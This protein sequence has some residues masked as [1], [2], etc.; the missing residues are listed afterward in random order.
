MKI[1]TFKHRVCGVTFQRQYQPLLDYASEYG[2]EIS[3]YD[4]DNLEKL[5][6]DYD[7]FF[8]CSAIGRNYY[9]AVKTL[10]EYGHPAKIILDYDDGIERLVPPHNSY[11]ATV[12]EQDIDYKMIDGREI[13]WKSGKTSVDVFGKPVQ[14]NAEENKARNRYTKE[15]RGLADKI[16]TTNT[17]L[18]GYLSEE[19]TNISVIPNYINPAYYERF[20]RDND[21]QFRIGWVIS[22]SHIND[23]VNM[24]P[25]LYEM[26]EKIPNAKLVIFTY[27]QIQEFEFFHPRCE[28][29][30]GVAF[31]RGYH[32]MFS[33]LQLDLGICHVENNE[34]N[35][36]KSP[37]KWLEYSACNVPTIASNDLY[38]QYGKHKH[39]MWVYNTK[40]EFVKEVMYLSKRP[41]LRKK[42]ADNARKHIIDNFTPDKV[43][44][45][46]HEVFSE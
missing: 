24:K 21:G 4:D 6:D 16:I 1:M 34:F 36:C 26:L 5:A 46:Y 43:L 8:V 7:I 28:I 11:Y 39:N 38:G 15:L 27:G 14:F 17:K 3:Y 19:S 2:A 13:S 41:E 22:S 12:G 33:R 25:Y 10:K 32:K 31:D 37:L 9:E 45:K 23:T 18:A 35:L 40:A 42:L 30:P 20:D 29:V 44:Y